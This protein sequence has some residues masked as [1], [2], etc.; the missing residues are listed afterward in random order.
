[1]P[2]EIIDAKRDLHRDQC[3]TG[4]SGSRVGGEPRVDPWEIE[5]PQVRARSRTQ[6]RQ[7]YPHVVPYRVTKAIDIIRARRAPSNVSNLLRFRTDP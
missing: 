6:G 1:M 7:R 2:R 3:E 5:R 4:E